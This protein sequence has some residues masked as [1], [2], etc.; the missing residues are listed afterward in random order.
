MDSIGQ[1]VQE[2][3]G[4]ER[5]KIHQGDGQQQTEIVTVLYSFEQSWQIQGVAWDREAEKR[6]FKVKTYSERKCFICV[7]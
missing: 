6:E 2:V 1:T 4:E 5:Q 3:K 7:N